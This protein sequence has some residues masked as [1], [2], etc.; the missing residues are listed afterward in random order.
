MMIKY[1][2]NFLTKNWMAKLMCLV[3]AFVLWVWVA[4]SQ[5]TIAKFPGTLPIK[6]I[7]TP[8]NLV[9]IYDADQVTVKILAEPSIWQRLSAETFSAEINLVGLSAGTHQVPVNVS[10][11]IAGVQIV[12]QTPTSILVTLEPLETKT[13]KLSERI[14]GSAADGM[15]PGDIVFE[16]DSV[17][18]KGAKS[19]I[20]EITEAV[21]A[22]SLNGQ[23]ADFSS[24]VTPMILDDKGQ[25]ISDITIMPGSVEA[26]ISIVKGSNTKTVGVKVQV[27]GV[28]KDNYYISNITSTP[29]AVDISGVQNT[30]LATSYLSTLPIDVTGA[31][32]EI[33]KDISLSVPSGL[34]ILNNNSSKIHVTISISPIQTSKTFNLNTF[35]ISSGEG[36]IISTD[37]ISIAAVCTGP[38]DQINSLTNSDFTILLNLS[39][40]K[41]DASGVIN[42]TV[43]PSDIQAPS[44]VTVT[45]ITSNELKVK[46]Q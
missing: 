15:V 21:A 5:N 12:D 16:P 38:I 34:I 29:G 2:K 7:N 1:I 35:K 37:P 4:S 41:A 30:V 22:I 20:S 25:T 11:S 28:P 23:D 43:A 36:K 13:I 32:S 24:T 27:D 14:E 3:A 9:A 17:R 46:I 40:Q 44:G 8:V 19:I 18:I 33:T 31:T 10:A 39:N 6:S 26:Q 45:S 42:L